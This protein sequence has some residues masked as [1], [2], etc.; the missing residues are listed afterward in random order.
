M[1]IHVTF[2]VK[3]LQN[4]DKKPNRAYFIIY[5]AGQNRGGES[6]CYFQTIMFKTIISQIVGFL[7]T[8]NDSPIVSPESM[9]R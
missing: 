9:G 6:R 3:L 7:N 1:F 4:D 2:D 5:S 8:I